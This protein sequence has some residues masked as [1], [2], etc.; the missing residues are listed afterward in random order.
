MAKD[1][2]SCIC[3]N[4]G[5][6]LKIERSLCPDCGLKLE[7]T[8]ELPRLAR[9]SPEDREFIE[10]FVLSAGSLKEVG[11]VMKL[12]YPTVRTRLDHVIEHLRRLDALHQSE[13]LAIM[14]RLER[15]E[16]SVPEAAKLLATLN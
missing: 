13:R 14:K 5:G 1:R 4:C 8:I 15:K 10:L 2:F 3:Q 7:G 16:I 6:Q 11:R 12:S 9:L